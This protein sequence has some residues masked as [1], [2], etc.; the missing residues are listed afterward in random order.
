MCE[1]VKDPA[2][3]DK[4]VKAT[5][6]FERLVLDK[7]A[8]F[9]RSNSGLDALNARHGATRAEF[10]SVLEQQRGARAAFLRQLVSLRME[11]AANCTDAEWEDL[12]DYRMDAL[13]NVVEAQKS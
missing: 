10:E 12:K 8:D 2:R 6:D 13:Q 4:L 9:R 11:M 3:A 1:V 7:E 5:S